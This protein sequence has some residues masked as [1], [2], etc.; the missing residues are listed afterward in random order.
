MRLEQRGHQR[1]AAAF[2]VHHKEATWRVGFDLW[3]QYF[4]VGVGDANVLN[5]LVTHPL[6]LTFVH[7]IEVISFGSMV[8]V[9]S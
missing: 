1:V 9:A 3:P 7:V 5:V 6:Q 4:P 8:R 2:N